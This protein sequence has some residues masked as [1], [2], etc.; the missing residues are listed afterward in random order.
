MFVSYCIQSRLRL[1][2][3]QMQN[4]N[5]R[6]KITML[7]RER[8]TLTKYCATYEARWQEIPKSEKHLVREMLMSDIGLKIRNVLLKVNVWITEV[9]R[10]ELVNWDIGT[11]NSLWSHGYGEASLRPLL[12]G[13][14]LGHRISSYRDRKIS[15]GRNDAR[16]NC[17]VHGADWSGCWM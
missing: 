14:I 11:K 7:R 5:V 4:K 12:L 3:Q 15:G 10:I 8:N 16:G 1:C 13:D 17:M 6:K 9:Y 2:H